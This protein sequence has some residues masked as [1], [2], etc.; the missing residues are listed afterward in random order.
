MQK[1]YLRVLFE[2]LHTLDVVFPGWSQRRED[3]A[4]HG[5]LSADSLTYWLTAERCRRTRD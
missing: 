2:L 4:E 1:L 3:P 5:A